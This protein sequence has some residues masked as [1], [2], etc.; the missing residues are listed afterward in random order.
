[1]LSWM[2]RKLLAMCVREAGRCSIVVLEERKEKELSC[3]LDKGSDRSLKPGVV[4]VAQVRKG[5][6][7]PRGEG[8]F[9]SVTW[10]L[11]W[12]YNG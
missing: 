3:F 8:G 7:E 2:L 6:A 9:F 5:I 4:E 10:E 12:S 11:L 1:M